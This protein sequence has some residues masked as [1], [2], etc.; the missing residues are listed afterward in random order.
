MKKMKVLHIY[1]SYY[2]DTLGGVEKVIDQIAANTAAL[3]IESQVICLTPEKNESTMMLN[4]YQVH[5][6]PQLFT[7]ASTPVSIKIFKHFKA[8]AEQADIIHYHF[9]WPLADLLHFITRIKKPR[10]VTYHADIIKQKIVLPFYRPLMNAFL[11]DMNCITA[12]SSH[13]A[14][15]SKVLSRFS[16]KLKI[17][18]IGLSQNSYPTPSI[19]RLDYW[20]EKFNFKFFVFIGVIRYYKGI[21]I[22]ITAAKE[23]GAPIIVIGKGAN[24]D[25]QNNPNIHFLGAVSEEDKI[26]LLTLAYGVVL[27]SNVRSEAFGIALLEGAMFSKPLVSCELGTG[28]TYINIHNETGQV[29]PPNDSIALRQAMQYLL[30]NPDE[31]LRMGTNA[32]ARYEQHFTAE[33]M[34]KAYVDIYQDICHDR[35]I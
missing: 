1:K 14:K 25:Q 24:V 10:L 13:Y 17:I 34:A 7:L 21:D 29:V 3:G 22:L 31:A 9:P 30:D 19:Q 27:S 5:R 23:L 18:P 15:T 16:D 35:A 8:L 11:S 26:A 28:T 32:R 33:K 6:V 2:P 20:R 12:T 4:G